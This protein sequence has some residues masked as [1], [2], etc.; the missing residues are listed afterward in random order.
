V[1]SYLF[2]VLPDSSFPEAWEAG[3]AIAAFAA[4]GYA[5]VRARLR[6]ASTAGIGGV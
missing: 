1:G 3:L 5:A 6:S 4:A 2:G